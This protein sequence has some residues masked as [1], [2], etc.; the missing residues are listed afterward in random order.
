MAAQ[1]IDDKNRKTLLSVHEKALKIEKNNKSTK[2]QRAKLV[3]IQTAHLAQKLKIKNIVF[4]RNG[5]RYHGR[6]KA[7]AEAARDGGLK[8]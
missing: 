6:I 4:D 8:F 2:T 1:L 5:Y 3:G 7:L